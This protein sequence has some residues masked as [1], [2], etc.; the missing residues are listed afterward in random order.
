M[1]HFLPSLGVRAFLVSALFLA[2]C[3]PAAQQPAAQQPAQQQPAAPAAG[4]SLIFF[5]NQ[6][7]PVTEQ[8]KMQDVILKNAPVKTEYIPEDPGPELAKVERR[9]GDGANLKDYHLDPPAASVTLVASMATCAP[10]AS[11]MRSV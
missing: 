1:R 7:K 11:S 10:R 5:S 8:A 2:A 3:A 4:G 6:F 9:L